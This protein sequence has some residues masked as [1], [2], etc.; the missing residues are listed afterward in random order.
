MV[1]RRLP[2]FTHGVHGA[3]VMID[4]RR[5]RWNGRSEL[6]FFDRRIDSDFFEFD[7]SHLERFRMGIFREVLRDGTFREE[8]TLL[9]LL[10]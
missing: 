6:A 5:T 3:L 8:Y 4:S 9:V 7:C 1:W 2:I 10:H